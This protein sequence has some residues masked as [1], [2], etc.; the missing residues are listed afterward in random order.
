[1][2]SARSGLKIDFPVKR[3]GRWFLIWALFLAAGLGLLAP[4][5]TNFFYADD[6]LHLAFAKLLSDP[7]TATWKLFFGRVFWR[8]MVMLTDFSYFKLFGLD[9]LGYHLADILLHSLNSLLVAYLVYLLLGAENR[10][11]WISALA[12]LVY[13]L[14]PI[15]LLTTAWISCRAD[16]LF[17]FF[18]LLS[19]VLALQGVVSHRLKWLKILLALPLSFL[20]YLSKETALILPG[21]IFLLVIFQ[22]GPRAA[23]KRTLDALL[24]LSLFLT[25]LGLYLWFRVK[26]IG[27]IGGYEP[28]ELTRGFLLPRLSYHLPRIFSR[29]FTDYLFWHLGSKTVW[30]WLILGSY[31]GF[32]ILLLIYFFRSPRIFLVGILW[33]LLAL[34]PLWNL[35]QM[36]FF[37][38][39]RLFYFGLAGG[40]IIFAGIFSQLKNR[41][42]RVAG[43]IL[44]ALLMISYGRTDWME[45]KNFQKHSR[46]YQEVKEATLKAIGEDQADNHPRRIYL[47]GL[48]FELYYLDMMFKIYQPTRLDRMIVPGD[49]PSL[50]WVNRETALAYEEQKPWWPELETQYSD[51][52]ISMV[53]VLPPA[54]LPL[55]NTHDPQSLVL[56]WKDGKMENIT[57]EV[58]RLFQDRRFLQENHQQKLRLFPSY[59]FRKRNYPLDWK[60]SPGIELKTPLH[61]AEL[62]TFRS[63]TEDPYL[64]S[65]PLNFLALATS[66]LEFKM[67]IQEKEYL[68]P[69]EQ[70]GCI[71]W[72]SSLDQRELEWQDQHKICFPID[73]DGKFHTYR[74]R[75][76]RNLSWLRSLKITRLRLDPISFPAWFQLDYLLF[77][78][79][80]SQNQ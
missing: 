60:L 80:P 69:Q 68:A 1:L 74:I 23:R 38:E 54:D 56:E 72:T 49:R 43:L 17:V 18:G 20:A 63:R 10:R 22:P 5:L 31:L 34:A 16:L 24:I 11:H 53:T 19:L 59:E 48:S 13:A 75:V 3:I 8:P 61:L 9:P 29:A 78:P 50:A 71:F 46:E 70:E 26:R 6:F 42:A 45:L 51:Q 30:F 55:A 28:M 7:F 64:I 36:L 44:F 41:Q 15:S 21:F 32:G 12:G 52:K 33:L 73:A 57:N 47:I 39:A 67:R 14:H 77:S 37:M 2:P 25:V 58:I 76:D 40:A 4:H 65:P 35:S 66:E 27:F 62:Y 79:T